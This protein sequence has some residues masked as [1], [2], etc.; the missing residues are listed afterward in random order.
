MEQANAGVFN[1]PNSQL[2]DDLNVDVPMNRSIGGSK[3]DEQKDL[4]IDELLMKRSQDNNDVSSSNAQVSNSAS[5]ATRQNKP[6]SSSAAKR[7][8][9]RPRKTAEEKADK[10]PGC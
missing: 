10:K 2:A 8:V 3:D 9:G 5:G 4:G 1:P 7:G 6:S